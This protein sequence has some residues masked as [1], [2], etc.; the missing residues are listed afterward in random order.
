MDFHYLMHLLQVLHIN[1]PL[2]PVGGRLVDPHWS[3][4]LPSTV[5]AMVILRSWIQ[6]DSKCE[7]LLQL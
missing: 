3:R 1:L 6:D 2:V 7:C 5:E 4:L